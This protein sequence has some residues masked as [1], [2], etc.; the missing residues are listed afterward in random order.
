M[1][2]LLEGFCAE[3]RPDEQLAVNSNGR[4]LLLRLGDIDWLEAAE[5]GVAL[6]AG[7]ETHLVKDTLAAMSLK[8]PRGRFLRISPSALVNVGQIKGLRRLCQSE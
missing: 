1:P 3:P 7:K 4:L 8:L 6:H 5:N 2:G